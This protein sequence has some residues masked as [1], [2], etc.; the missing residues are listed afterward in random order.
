[1]KTICLIMFSVFGISLRSY[2]IFMLRP[3]LTPKKG[4]LVPV[5]TIFERRKRL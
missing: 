1:M 2:V 5:L 4:Y 3:P